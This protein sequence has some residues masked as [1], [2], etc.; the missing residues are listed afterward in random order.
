M[1]T[2]ASSQ[3]KEDSIKIAHTLSEWFTEEGIRNMSLDFENNHLI[4]EKENDEVLGFLCYTTYCG[5]M[6]LIWMGVK[7]DL[8]NKGTGQRLLDW[9]IE[10]T[11]RLNLQAIE[12]E[13]LPEEVDYKPYDSTR[14]FYYKNG[15]KKILYKKATTEGWD[16]QIVLERKI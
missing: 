1:I 5:K 10:E 2:E 14:A 15:F 13:T 8:L 7:R 3:D 16:D 9:L 4:V 11:K 6:L 12:V